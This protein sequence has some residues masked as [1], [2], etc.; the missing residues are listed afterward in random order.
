MR[1]IVLLSGGLDSTVLLA[2]ALK[3]QRECYALS[4]DYGQRHR[5]ELD[6]AKKIARH[7]GVDHRIIAIDPTVFAKSSLVSTAAV[8]KDRTPSQIS[9]GS[10]PNTYV[11]A[12][13]TL[14]LAYALGQ[15]EIQDAKEIYVGFN[16]LDRLPYPDCR[17]EFVHAFQA[18]IQ[19]ATKQSVEG[20]PPKI[21][22]P[23]IDWDKCEIIRQGQALNAPLDLTFSCY[24]PCNNQPCLR[25]DACV[26]RH[27]AFEQ[28][29]IEEKDKG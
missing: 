11:P 14:F 26:L 23:L 15:A 13:N 9:S 2:I 16:A 8:P 18:L 12:R 28:I 29:K 24:D 20:E 10:I 19:V 1:A 3:Q 21:M 7:Y 4:F 27:A 25:C 22:T 5:I 6:S 17:P